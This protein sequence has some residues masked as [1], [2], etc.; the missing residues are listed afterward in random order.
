MRLLDLFCGAG[1]AAVGYHR[2]GFTEIVGVDSAL[3]KRYPF[4][5]VRADALEYLAEHGHEFDA[6]HASPPCQAYGQLAGFC[7]HRYGVQWL[8]KYP[9]LIEPLRSMLVASGKP[10]VIE[11]SPNA[12]LLNTV[13]LCGSMFGLRVF[14]HRAFEVN[15][16]IWRIPHWPHED[17]ITSGAADNRRLSIKNRRISPK[18]YVC[19]VGNFGNYEYAKTAMGID[20]MIKAEMAEAIPPAFTEYIGEYLLLAAKGGAQ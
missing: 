11:N 3:M 10:Y 2:A 17:K 6:I 12:P 9:K 1:G 18:G 4:R 5:F 16:A 20:W 13:E 14:R 7:V 8:D 19:L 15:F